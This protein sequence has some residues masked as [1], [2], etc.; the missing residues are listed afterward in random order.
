MVFS[1]AAR[2]TKDMGWCFYEAG[3]FRAKLE[4]ETQSSIL[5][6]R[7]CC[8][9]DSERPNQLARYQGTQ[10]ANCNR[11]GRK[12]NLDSESNDSL[13]YEDTE[14]F[15]LLDLIIEKSTGGPLRDLTDP[16]VRKLMRTGVRRITGAFI[17]NQPEEAIGEVVFQPRISFKF[18]P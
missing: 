1:G 11:A 6:S 8:L 4:R 15:S 2:P 14:L 18:L 9:Y 7:M 12:L 3:Q 16:N 13:D 10:I 17:R 5:R